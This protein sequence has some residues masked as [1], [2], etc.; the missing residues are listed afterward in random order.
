MKNSRSIFLFFL[1]LAVSSCE[2]ETARQYTEVA[3][4]APEMDK[5]MADPH[6]G[7]D[8]GMTGGDDPHAFMKNMGSGDP[9]AGFTK[10]QLQE[11]LAAQGGM[12]P[13][14]AK[15]PVSWSVPAGWEEKSG[16]GMRVASFASKADPKAVDVSIVTLGGGA[17]GIEP[18]IVRW[19]QQIQLDVPADA[20]LKE[21][22]DEQE[23]T[24]TADDRTAVIFDFTSLQ[25]GAAPDADSMAAAIIDT[26]GQRIFVKM[27]GSKKNV[28]G[29]MKNF[30]SLVRSL[31]IAD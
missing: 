18:N 16:G 24:R 8:M 30:K 1:V 14:A 22:I 9:H 2:K 5:K 6:A 10:E 28:L 23:K 13:A 25:K 12:L 29:E 17:G 11:M 31:K 19:L 26:P 15:L 4:P 20:K 27:T 3:T 21:F 7:L